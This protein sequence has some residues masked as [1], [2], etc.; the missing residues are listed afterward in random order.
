MN[1]ERLKAYNKWLWHWL[2]LSWIFLFVELLYWSI[3]K[4]GWWITAPMI[5]VLVCC[6]IGLLGGFVAYF[7]SKNV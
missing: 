7:R 1:Y 5:G 6:G 2:Y 4:H 3:G